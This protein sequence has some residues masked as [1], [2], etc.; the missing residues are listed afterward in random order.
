[1]AALLNGSREMDGPVLSIIDAFIVIKW[2]NKTS[3]LF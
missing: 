3:T 2:A 1:M